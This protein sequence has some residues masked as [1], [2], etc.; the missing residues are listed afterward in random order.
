MKRLLLAELL[1][2]LITIIFVSLNPISRIYIADYLEKISLF[3]FRT[4][5]D[6]DLN[7]WDERRDKYELLE[8]FGG[9]AY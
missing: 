4:V 8:E 3:L 5:S 7:K 2:V 1:L 6:E 9:A